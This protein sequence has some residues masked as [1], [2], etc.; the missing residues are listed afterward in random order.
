MFADVVFFVV[1]LKR[2]VSRPLIAPR[3]IHSL[4]YIG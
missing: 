1:K 3:R 2:M 4:P